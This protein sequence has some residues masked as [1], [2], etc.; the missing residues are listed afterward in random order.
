LK[1]SPSN[2]MITPKSCFEAGMARFASSDTL[3]SIVAAAASEAARDASDAAR[4]PKGASAAPIG[5]PMKRI[6]D[7]V[8]ATLTLAFMAPVLFLIFVL[9][10]T[11]SP[12]P[13]LYRHR[14]IGFNGR[15]FDCL[16][17]RTMVTDG[18]ERL[19]QLLE[20]D[21]AAAAEWSAT[22]KLRYDPRITPIGSILR[23]AHLEELPQLFN[24]LRGDMSLVGPHPIMDEE[25]ERYGG[26]V[27]SY[28][29]CKPGMTGLWQVSGRGTRVY[30]KRVACDVFYARNWSLKL[31]SKIL[32]L[33]LPGLLVSEDNAFFSRTIVKTRTP[34]A[35]RASRALKWRNAKAWF[36]TG[37]IFAIAGLV[38]S[39]VGAAAADYSFELAGTAALALGCVV[40]TLA[41]LRGE[42][43]EQESG[44]HGA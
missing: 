16:K 15:H 28:L 31:D 27:G 30:D 7:V 37:L 23:N 34:A 26:S 35:A 22:R 40:A 43:L 17:F 2:Y 32:A 38:G 6:V 12:G 20:A 19:R 9:I 13:V 25:L 11:S 3:S 24:V 36:T 29:S 8:L 18:P 44:I 1:Y 42:Q 39:I 41:L 33:A 4:A 21:P 14:R 10:K 5:M